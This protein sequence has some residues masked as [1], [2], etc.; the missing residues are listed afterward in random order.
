[1][2]CYTDEQLKQARLEKYDMRVWN[3]DIPDFHRFRLMAAAGK[4]PP[5]PILDAM[6][7]TEIL[8]SGFDIQITCWCNCPV[9]WKTIPIKDPHTQEVIGDSGYYVHL[10]DRTV[11]G[12]ECVHGGNKA[13][14]LLT[15]GS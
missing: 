7:G 4:P 12:T 3:G 8:G 13:E 2:P 14:R 10:V 15:D 1:M 11:A 6:G 9:T 5:T